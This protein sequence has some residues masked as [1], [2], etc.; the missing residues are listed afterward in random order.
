MLEYRVF[1]SGILGG[2]IYYDEQGTGQDGQGERT[3]LK[4]HHRHVFVPGDSSR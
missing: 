3:I 1:G 2:A 4:R